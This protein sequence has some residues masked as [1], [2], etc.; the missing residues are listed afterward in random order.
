LASLLRPGEHSLPRRRLPFF[1]E[2]FVY[3]FDEASQL[4]EDEKAGDWIDPAG[5]GNCG[6]IVPSISEA[7]VRGVEA[8]GILVGFEKSAYPDAKDSSEENVGVEHQAFVLR[9]RF[10]F[11]RQCLKLVTA[12]SSE[13]P[14]ESR[15]SCQRAAASFK[16]ARS[17]SSRLRR[18]GM[19]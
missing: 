16:A 5:R 10:C 1:V 18:A 6:N 17:A 14:S 2:A 8:H 3:G 7:N 12:S 9:H 13:M 15:I 4:I 19:K 11:A